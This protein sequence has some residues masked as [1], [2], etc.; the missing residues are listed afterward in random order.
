MTQHI[1]EGTWE[2]IVEEYGKELAGRRVRLTVVP[3]ERAR[4]NEKLLAA[5]REAELIFFEPDMVYSSKDYTILANASC[6]TARILGDERAG[7]PELNLDRDEYDA[8]ATEPIKARLKFGHPLCIEWAEEFQRLTR[9][10]LRE[11]NRVVACGRC[12]EIL[13]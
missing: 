7:A 10:V 9:F 12:L 2:E 4:P 13:G 8:R 6:S 1:I 5:I 11:H 3:E